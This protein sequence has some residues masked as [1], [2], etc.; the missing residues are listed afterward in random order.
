[1]SGYGFDLAGLGAVG[2]DQRGVS[3]T[4]TAGASAA[5]VVVRAPAA[6]ADPSW[7]FSTG[8]RRAFDARRSSGASPPRERARVK[9]GRGRALLP[10]R[11]RRPSRS[12]RLRQTY[13]QPTIS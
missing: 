2:E 3:L 12:M 6:A 9:R 1:R 7:L 10:T 13:E 4:T 8:G 11:R 5:R